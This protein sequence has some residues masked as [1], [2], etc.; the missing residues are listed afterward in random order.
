TIQK[1]EKQLNEVAQEKI[2]LFQQNKELQRDLVANQAKFDTQQSVFTQLQSM[3]AIK[4][5]KS[6]D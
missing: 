3:L 2:N 5:T 4:N 1:L 6:H